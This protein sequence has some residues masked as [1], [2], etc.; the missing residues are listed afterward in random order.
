MAPARLFSDI[1]QREGVRGGVGSAQRRLEKTPLQCYL[2]EL[3]I[4]G[5]IFPSPFPQFAPV[6]VLWLRLC[7][8]GSLGLRAL[9]L[10]SAGGAV[11]FRLSRQA[12]V[13]NGK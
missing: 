5:K 13:T 2:Q 11:H 6:R 12:A 9:A 8:A 7:R 1:L 4:S 10:K 3:R